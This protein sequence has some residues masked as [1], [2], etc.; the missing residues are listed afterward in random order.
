MD[1]NIM[2]SKKQRSWKNLL[3]LPGFQ[4]KITLFVLFGGIGCMGLN[5]YLYYI[6]VVESYDFIFKASRLP[7]E[8][9][10]DRYN[11]LFTFGISLGAITLA[12][13]L[14]IAGAVLVMTHRAA[15]AVYKMTKV[16]DEVSAGNTSV[17]VRLRDK[18][19]FQD[20]AVS[21]NRLI[22]SIDQKGAPKP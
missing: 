22:D 20:F 6:Y 19:H 5:A 21:I 1:Q 4:G 7:Q 18:D 15:G 12:V 16:V 10:H 14:V 9:I 8:M 13:I 17:R 11:D 2:D 3:L